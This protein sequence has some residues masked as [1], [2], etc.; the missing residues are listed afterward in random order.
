MRMKK[1][2]V[3]LGL[4]LGCLLI[5]CSPKECFVEG[6]D[7]TFVYK[8]TKQ[9]KRYGVKYGNVISIPPI[10]PFLGKGIN[11]YT[12]FFSYSENWDTFY[13]FEQNGSEILTEKDHNLVGFKPLPIKSFEEMNQGA[14]RY[15]GNIFYPGDYYLFTLADGNIYALFVY[16]SHYFPF[17]S[18]QKFFPGN[19][20]FSY[21]R[22]NKWGAMAAQ[23]EVRQELRETISE[24]EI[25]SAEY[26]EI[27]EVVK[28]RT[29]CVWF[30]RSGDKWISRMIG[31]DGIVRSVAVDVKLLQRVRNM[32]IQDKARGRKDG[33]WMVLIPGQR[34]G[35]KEASVVFL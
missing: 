13:F 12:M 1:I 15:F 35:T 16:R 6:S 25:F 19:T 10:Y 21:K 18:Y 9:G 11:S 17:G 14:D 31:E 29:N 22:N 3:L 24:Q 23:M 30:A 4:V 7:V 20:G 2:F 8:N 26:E 32:R 34:I 28:S 5:S 27:I 33:M